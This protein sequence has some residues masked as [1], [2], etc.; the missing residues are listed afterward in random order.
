MRYLG[1]PATAREK[2]RVERG[3]AALDYMDG[4]LA[5][6][7]WL[8]AD[9]FTIADISLLAYTRLAPE[10]GFKLDAHRNLCD[11]IDRCEAKLG[12]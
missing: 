7:T 10:G 11:W 4:I 5:G 12:L 3:E 8:A 1:K 2:W 9:Q 6:R